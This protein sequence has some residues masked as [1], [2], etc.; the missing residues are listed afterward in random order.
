MEIL[1]TRRLDHLGL[2]MGT[3]KEFGVINLIDQKITK[4]DQHTVSTGEAIAAMVMNGLGFVNRPLSLT[5]QFFETKALDVLFE[6]EIEADVL[7]RHKLGRALDSIHEYGCEL[8]FSEVASHVCQQVEVG[9]KFTS[10]DTTSF[11]VSGDYDCDTDENE[12]KITHGYSKDHRPDLK[13]AVLELV[14]S[15]DGGIPLMMK[16]FNGNASDN[17]VFKQRCKQLITAFKESDAPRYLV[18]DSKL[19]CE[20]NAKN[21]SNIKF[22]TR[23]PRTYKAEINAI[24]EAINA[25]AWT[26]IDDSN[27]YYEHHIK[28][29]GIE[30]R[31][32]VIYSKAAQLRAEVTI[33]RQ[34][35]KEYKSAEK[36]LMHLRNKEFNCEHDGINALNQLSSKFKYHEIILDEVISSKRYDGRGRPKKT[37]VS[38]KTIYQITGQITSI[39]NARRERLEQYSC[40]IISTNAQASELKSTDV[41]DAY[42]NQNASIERGFRFLKDPQFFASSFFLKKPSRIMALLMVMTL[43]LLV[44]TVAQRHLRNQLTEK[45]DTL[46]NQIND[47]VK[48][49]TMRWVFQLMEGIDIVYIRVK[50]D[51]QRKIMGITDL[52][53]KI[54]R[55]FYPPVFSIY[56]V[57]NIKADKMGCSM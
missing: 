18:G 33:N 5:P 53:E 30:Q 28:H 9:E 2:V 22:I 11:S 47:P 52:R 45:N 26:V 42:K 40:Y 16:C 37:D 17:K 49:P 34:I 57:E 12:I 54:I 21:L 44:Y 8:L 46:P 23:I 10:L 25:N 20:D 4:D 19:Y 36:A 29:M 56:Q 7:N 55:F 24:N 31:W 50:D 15:Q 38:A 39:I 35:A 27:K 6:R 43:S 13:Q 51:I 32:L 1:R 3:L 48:N 14:T 41:I